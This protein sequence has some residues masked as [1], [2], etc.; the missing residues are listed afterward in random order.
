LERANLLRLPGARNI[1]AMMGL[2][3]I[4][5]IITK[6]VIFYFSEFQLLGAE[7]HTTNDLIEAGINKMS[8]PLP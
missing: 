7:A 6:I 8:S 2:A 1:S 5:S 4:I 3:M